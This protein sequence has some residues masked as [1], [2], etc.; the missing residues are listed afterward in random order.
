MGLY[1][2]LNFFDDVQIDSADIDRQLAAFKSPAPPPQPEQRSGLGEI[3]SQLKAGAFVDLP[4]MAG[5]AMQ[6][7][8]SPGN[9][10]Y[11]K[12]KSLVEATDAIEKLPEMMPGDTTGRPVVDALSKGAR[13]IPQSIAP[14]AGVGLTLSGVG[15]PA[16][17]ALLGGSALA[18]LPAGM[19]QAQETFEKGLAK[20]GLTAEQAATMQGDPRVQ[21]ALNAARMTG[22]IEWGGETAAGAI[23]GKLLGIGGKLSRPLFGK[24]LAPVEQQAAAQI[25]KNFSIPTMAAN[26]GKQVFK[27]AAGET[28]TEMAQ[29]A[30]EAG[31]EQHYGYDQQTPWD[32][33]KSAVL[34]SLGMTALLAPFGIPA[35]VAHSRGMV[36]AADALSDPQAPRELRSA[37]AEQVYSEL[38]RVSPEAASN[39]A[40]RSYD[41]IHGHEETGSAP[42]GLNL[43][44]DSIQPFTPGVFNQPEQE[45]DQTAAPIQP[46]SDGPLGK[47]LASG[48]VGMQQVQEQ[49]AEQQLQQHQPLNRLQEAR[50]QFLQNRLDN[51]AELSETE[52]QQMEKLKIRS[53]GPAVT[54]LLGG[55]SEGRFPVTMPQPDELSLANHWADEQ[56]RNGMTHLMNVRA[57]DKTGQALIQEWKRLTG[58]QQQE[59]PGSLQQQQDIV[60]HP[61]TTNPVA[62]QKSP[63]MHGKPNRSVN[64]AQHDLIT[65]IAKMGGLSRDQAVTQWGNIK[66]SI[67][68]LNKHATR[69]GGGGLQYAIHAKGK[70]LDTMRELLEEHGYLQHGSTVEDMYAR[71]EA[72]TRGQHSYSNQHQTHFEQNMSDLPFDLSDLDPNLD[73]SI[74]YSL[75][76]LDNQ[77]ATHAATNNQNPATGTASQQSRP[78]F[79]LTID[80]VAKAFPNQQIEEGA[81]GF[82]VTLKNGAT[83]RVN[84]TD[85]IQFN[86]KAAE[87]SYGR[88]L[89]A[90]EKPVA[91]FQRMGRDA[92]I[93]LTEA[94]TGEIHHETFHA[95]M[96]LAL[97]KHQ[98]DTLL[99]KFG[100]EEAAA[101]EYQ[102]L[103]DSGSLEHEK[104]HLWLRAIYRFFQKLRALFNPVHQVMQD[105]ASGEV[106]NSDGTTASAAPAYSVKS[107]LERI[108]ASRTRPNDT[109]QGESAIIGS[110]D[111]AIE[112]RWQ[113]AHG[114]SEGPNLKERL[115]G[116]IQRMLAERQHFPNLDTS[117]FSGKRTADILRRFESSDVA[118]KAK[119]AEYLHSLTAT[120]GPKK[121]DLFS[122]KV[123]LDDLIN[124]ADKGRALPFG[125]TP[126]TVKADH[127]RITKLVQA[128]PDVQAAIEKRA[129][130][131]KHL[132]LELVDNNLLP[133]ESVLTPEGLENYKQTGNYGADDI[134]TGY[135]RHQ[136]LEHANARKWAGIST[137]G[138]VRN[139]QRGWQKGREGSELDINTNFLEAE[140]E[141][142]SQ[143]MKELAT[144]KALDEVLSINDL[145]PA[146]QEQAKQEGAADWKALIP[147]GYTS[148][149]PEKGSIFY[150]GQTLP[151]SIITRFAEQNPA[152]AD[153]VQK[154]KEVLIL[155]GRKEE[156][157]IPEGLAKTLDNLRTNREDATLDTI[158]K[159]LI[160]GW[161]VWTLL[162]PRRALK[163]NLNNMSGDLD[164]ALA[165]DPGILKHFGTA[166]KNALNRKAGKPMTAE[167]QAMLERGVIDAGISINEIPDISKLPGFQHLKA[168]AR[169]TKL[170][171]ALKTGDLAKLAPANLIAKYFDKVSS[172]T[173]LREGLLREAAYLRAKELL[174][175][176]KTIYWASKPA[177]I[178]AIPDT[179][180][181]AAKLSREL[182]GDYGNLSAHGE[183]IRTSLIPFWSWMEINAPRY[184][185][186]FKNAA[187]QGE[188][189]ST[190]VRMAGVGTRKVAGAALGIAEKVLFTHLMFAAVSAFNHLVHPD[191]EDKLAASVRGQL[192]L[193]LGST[194]DGKTLTL[195]FS[196]A[197][198]DVL[199]WAGLE[200][201]PESFKKLQAGQMDAKEMLKKMTLATPNK[202]VNAASP[203][204]K[205]AGELMTGKSI[206][207]DMTKPVP[208]RDKTEHI[209]RFFALDEEY[210]ALAGKPGKGYLNS[211]K[212]LLVYESDPGEQAYHSTRQQISRF[213][214]KHG[215]EQVTAEP[216]ERSKALYYF[217][218]AMKY[219]DKEAIDKYKTA[220]LK[221]GGK[222]ENLYQS[223]K[224]AH[225]LAGLPLHMRQQFMQQLPAQERENI[226][227][228][229]DWYKQA[230]R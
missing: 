67:A 156:V 158:N 4:R 70:P 152:F 140:F 214:E 207:P 107:A 203:F 145:A 165:A 68:D 222:P 151:E 217:R 50:L 119:T 118:A 121:M 212:N 92:V 66:D 69:N 64:P 13:M 176:G 36:Q 100:T 138:E 219:R 9:S 73:Q 96:A 225:P 35:H 127:E 224:R 193:I 46:V 47:A 52:I 123:V 77:G 141:Y 148:W 84:G 159:K 155:G 63:T 186:L 182:L 128:N 15:A 162:S 216:T 43:D 218:Q 91:S 14:A 3:W 226:K 17:V 134:N 117:S 20:H 80:Q 196:G 178:N 108:A 205:L 180:D 170:L 45:Q 122:R 12:G 94:G 27:T 55:P 124:E 169:N 184:Y 198:S 95:A 1:D 60:S 166:W 85:E 208:I 22:G 201:Y 25:L 78:V 209:A 76:Q 93:A 21:D 72:A 16:G 137:A 147:E 75:K 161:K 48:G 115:Q 59:T 113:A 204:T 163:Y 38:A 102:R 99:A 26:Y 58:Q 181:K 133:V 31:V 223:I 28:A 131:S 41:A 24:F 167:E 74:V 200:D 61:L 88:Q 153:V 79:S 8:S 87:A 82:T 143:A 142:Y 171:E 164:I 135:F 189:G 5:R 54:E 7:S 149:Q 23:G 174:E 40:A 114:L 42:Y 30:A 129:E 150:K 191:E 105:I 220:Y 188:A 11:E 65:A 132:V 112:Q 227:L 126:E 230:Y 206:Y 103:K 190:A 187:T 116:F 179:R 160:G 81:E 210:K 175:Q 157:V 185:R 183:K 139:K 199:A 104:G 172:L 106:W 154:F 34:P 215:R 86:S 195:R 97:N 221:A 44:E 125:Y 146:L 229:V 51:G 98:R 37:A 110:T 19:A 213:L 192:H 120:F 173:Q 228:A 197:F 90:D 39:F 18:A 29:S 53:A 10:I 194:S 130:V 6:Y 33:A 57:F 101:Q 202:L 177:E 83:I 71:I 144:K 2:R 111:P 109:I 62:S 49:Q 32:A 211:L 56:I 89:Q 136:V 168:D